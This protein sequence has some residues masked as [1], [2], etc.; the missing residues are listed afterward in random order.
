MGLVRSLLRKDHRNFLRD[1]REVA[2]RVE[3]KMSGRRPFTLKLP[4]EVVRE[5]GTR[6]LKE[7]LNLQS[8][9]IGPS[10]RLLRVLN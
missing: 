5:L 7:V 3:E 2:F 6:D 8:A 1:Q 4:E 9:K 10:L